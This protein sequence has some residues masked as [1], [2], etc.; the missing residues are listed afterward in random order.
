MVLVFAALGTGCPPDEDPVFRMGRL[1]ES[2]KIG[3]EDVQ[4]IQSEELSIQFTKI[5]SDSRC[6]TGVICVTAGFVEVEI[7]IEKD[8]NSWGTYSLAI[9]EGTEKSMIE[10]DPLSNTGGYSFELLSVEPYPND[11]DT[12]IPQSDYEIELMVKRL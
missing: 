8:G 11:P 2:F 7:T 6:P 1:D 5:V 9:G 4:E 3:F 12:T 10:V